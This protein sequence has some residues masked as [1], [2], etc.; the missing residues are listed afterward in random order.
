MIPFYVRSLSEGY[1]VANATHF[2]RL[3]HL[4]KDLQK[5]GVYITNTP[6]YNQTKKRTNKHFESMFTS[7]I[8]SIVNK[9]CIPDAKKFGYNILK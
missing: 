1:E 9:W 5:M 4:A 8:L 7:E 3:E 2:L 6:H